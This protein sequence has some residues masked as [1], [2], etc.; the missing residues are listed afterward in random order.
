[1]YTQAEMDELDAEARCPRCGFLE[2]GTFC[3]YECYG[4]MSPADQ[5]RE[6]ADYDASAA[7][8]DVRERYA[9]AA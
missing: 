5:A 3:Q 2:G 8:D 1:M 7:F 9:G 4:G 6:A